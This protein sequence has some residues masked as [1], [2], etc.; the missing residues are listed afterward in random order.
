M[1]DDETADLQCRGI[2]ATFHDSAKLLKQLRDTTA[3]MYHSKPELVELI[4]NPASMDITKMTGGGLAHD[5]CDSARSLGNTL[6]T[7]IVES[8]NQNSPLD[9][10]K[11]QVYQTNCF[12]HLRNV[13]MD[14]GSTSKI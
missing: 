13:W 5:S 8:S 3:D 10:F 7:T 6:A 1:C 12:K 2:I 4:P 11:H 14:A 9:S